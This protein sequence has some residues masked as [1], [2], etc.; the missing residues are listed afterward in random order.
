MTATVEVASV[1]AADPAAVWAR[2]TTLDGVNAELMPLLR[3]TA[4]QGARLD[5]APL[6]R[7]WFRS[8]LLLAGRLP[9]GVSHL[10]LV[11]VDPG[12][13]FLE[14]SPMT[15]MAVWEHERTLEADAS[16]TLVRDRLLARPRLPV[17]APVVA[18]LVR[19]LFEH[20]HR[21]LRRA[22]S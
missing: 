10:T 1:V 22:F 7:A 16:G 4:P 13:G 12:R 6:D 20:R 19:A 14:R 2:I 8:R 18:W 21:R 9:V 15:G 3:M 17:P 11:R 5:D